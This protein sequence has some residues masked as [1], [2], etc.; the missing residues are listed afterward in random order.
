MKHRTDLSIII[1]SYNTKDL[2][3][4]CLRTLYESLK[5]SKIKTEVVVIDNVSTD[6]TKEMIG[7]K[8]PKVTLVKNKENVGF[9]RANN[10]GIKMASGDQILLLNTDIVVLK[11]AIVKL[12]RQSKKRGNAFLGG[13]LYNADRTSQ[14]SCG[15]F[16]NLTTVMLMLFF[17][18]DQLGI[19]RFSPNKPIKTD[20]ISGACIIAPKKLFLK[21]LL[22]DESIFMYMDEVDLLYRARK[23][24]YGTYFYPS[25]RFIHYGAASSKEKKKSPVINI[26]RGLIYFYKKHYSYWKLICLYIMLK[27]KAGVGWIIGVLVGNKYLKSTYGE[28]FWMV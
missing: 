20:W 1:V 6:G 11:D 23:M 8:Y 3:D 16:F 17:K 24:G 26:Y 27:T 19:T 2:T 4:D 18:G 22:F 9:G 12:Y 5:G 14:A 10:Q 21:N 13:K 25:A 28:A 7:K 15:P